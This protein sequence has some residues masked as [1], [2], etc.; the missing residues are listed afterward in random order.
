MSKKCII[1]SQGPVPTPEHKK[2]EGGGL[3]CWGLAKGLKANDTDMQVTVAYHESYKKEEFTDFHEDITVA[4]W[5]VDTLP[6]LL[7]QFDSVVVSYCMGPLSVKT[8]DCLRPDQ[9]LI[10]DCY[11][12]IYVEVSARDSDDLDREYNAFHSDLGRWAHVLRRGDLF[13]CASEAQ[14]KYY[15][16]VLSAIG[17]INPATYGEELI[18]IAPY[19]IYRD[20]PSPTEKPITKITQDDSVK[21][22]LWFGGI[23]PWF[24][25]RNLVDA[26][27]LLNKKVP[28]KLIIVGAKNPFNDHPDFVRPYDE[29]IE[30]IESK[31]LGDMVILQDWVKFEDRANWYLDSDL[32]VVINKI[33]EENELA[34]RTRL[35]DFIW[36]NLPII[37]NGGDPLG[38]TLL[39]ENAAAQ[40]GSLEPESIATKLAAVL[41]D[42]KRI[43]TMREQLKELKKRYYW[44]V[45][46]QATAQHI[47]DHKIPKDRLL[48]GEFD[49][50][51]SA[52]PVGRRLQLLRAKKAYGKAKLLPA[53]AKKYGVLNTYFT[54][55]TKILSRAMRLKPSTEPRII[56]VAH[57]LDMSG[58]PFVFMDIAEN[59]RQEYPKLPLEFHTFNPAHR[60]NIR[61]LNQLGI[62]PRIHLSKE[63][64]LHYNKGDVVVLNTVAHTAVF[65]NSLFDALD[66]GIVNKLIWFVHEDEPELIF[67]PHDKKRI[68]KLL[69]DNKL[70]IFA[71]AEQT[72]KHYQEFFDNQQNIRT[73]IYKFIVPEKFHKVR[74]DDAFNKLSFILTGTIGDGRKGQLPILYAFKAFMD[75]F[76]AVDK[77]AYR[78]FELVYVGLDNDFLSH[79]I[80]KHAPKLL[81]QR[82]KHHG[83]VTHEQSSELMMASNVTICYSMRECLPL[84]VFEGMAAG[85]PILRNDSSGMKEQLIDGK[86]GYYLDSENFDQVVETL[87]KILNREKTPN[88]KLASMS[89]SSYKIATDQA[90]NS[91]DPLIDAALEAFGAK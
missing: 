81:G 8:V 12:P 58:A 38:E 19:G 69:A 13:L 29:L 84:F 30:H 7:S 25:L 48:Y 32:V 68:R 83:R 50:S 51:Q 31:K 33:G 70:V 53:Y 61:R 15:K 21:K 11:V 9:Q 46:T 55:R 42:P 39:G 45:V 65:K 54:V 79:Q 76:E 74:E 3:R 60:D 71:A 24:D 28:A 18:I 6:E 63:I 90:K 35:V 27:A 86:N 56:F 17:R 59:V 89:A 41:T 22:I 88:K 47:K 10:L 64:G 5:D 2:V 73:Q 14:L 43:Q 44:D 34:W 20:E 37:T 52:P 57:Q 23:Y 26:V 82:F 62:K 87:E 75:R 77:K 49:A 66:A 36:A 80:L 91:Y 67:D 78:E 72:V 85:H 4:T 1:L 40:L 16:G